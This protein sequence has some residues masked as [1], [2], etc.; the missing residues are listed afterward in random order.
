[1]RVSGVDFTLI[2]KYLAMAP[3]ERL[4]EW[5]NKRRL[6][7]ELRKHAPRLQTILEA[8]I[9]WPYGMEAV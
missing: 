7:Q 4:R 9:A 8:L 2:R 3:S 1:M 5:Y 6:A